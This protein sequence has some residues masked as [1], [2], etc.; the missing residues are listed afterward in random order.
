M[1]LWLVLALGIV[2]AGHSVAETPVIRIATGEYPPWTSRNAP[3]H[4]FVNR[5]IREAFLRQ[6]YD[7]DFLY[8]PWPRALESAR[9]G[10]ADAT[11]FW[12]TDAGRAQHFY[13][14]E[15]ISDHAEVF[16]Y[17]GDLSA[18]SWEDLNDLNHYVIGATRGYTYTEQF[19]QL[20]EDKT[21]MVEKA[22]TD[23]QNFEKLLLGR[24][25]LFPAA[26]TVAE[27]VLNDIGP[28]AAARVSTL[29]KP[30]RQQ[31]G[32]LLFGKS[33]PQAE[34]LLKLFNQGLQSMKQDG[35][36]QRYLQEMQEGIY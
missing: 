3:H 8:Y 32:H 36:Y 18:P 5:V 31:Q 30:L 12:F 25:D 24:I 19:W 34:R 4:G 33:H 20:A 6:G 16:F 26:K 9:N 22:R 27:Q 23:Q 1:R 29:E 11:S 21:L 14:S 7:T 28:D 10:Q 15:P 35:T 13:Y 17:H 2:L